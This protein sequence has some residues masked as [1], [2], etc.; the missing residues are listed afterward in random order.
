MGLHGGPHGRLLRK[1]R[2]IKWAELNLGNLSN[3]FSRHGTVS[4]QID[5]AISFVLSTITASQS[6]ICSECC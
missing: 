5:L 4:S 1:Q 3:S 6:A 2:H